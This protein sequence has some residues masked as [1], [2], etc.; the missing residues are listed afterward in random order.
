MQGETL[1][2]LSCILLVHSETWFLFGYFY[3]GG[4][5]VCFVFNCIVILLVQEETVF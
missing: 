2:K 5:D 3:V 4:I 1:F